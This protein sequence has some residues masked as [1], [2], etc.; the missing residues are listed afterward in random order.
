YT[1]MVPPQP[2]E[3]STE[4][5]Y[6]LFKQLLKDDQIAEVTLEGDSLSGYFFSP[7]A[8]APEQRINAVT[9]EIESYE[10][11]VTVLPPVADTELLPLL[12][13][14]RVDFK[15]KK[16][17]EPPYWLINLLPWLIII[18]IWLFILSSARKQGGL[19]GGLLNKM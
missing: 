4:I 13:E 12:E 7:V 18:G 1:L 9:E 5:G 19:T 15:A 17:D 6:S 2:T 8:L 11:F 3:T 14:H 16:A 10:H